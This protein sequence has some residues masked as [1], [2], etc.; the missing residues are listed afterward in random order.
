MKLSTIQ[1]FSSETLMHLYPISAY[2]WFSRTTT[3]ELNFRAVKMLVDTH[4]TSPEIDCSTNILDWGC[5]NLMWAL[6]LFPDASVTGVELSKE[7]L[8]YARINA[9]AANLKFKFTGIEYDKNISLCKDSFDYAISFGLIEFLDYNMF[10]FIFSEIYKALKPG[11]KLIV[12][13]HNWRLFSA[14][15]LPWIMRGGYAAYVDRTKA[16]ISKKTLL[17][18]SSDFSKLRFNV[19]DS[20]GYNPY[21]SKLWPLVFSEAFYSTHNTRLS[22]WYYSQFLVLQKTKW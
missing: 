13:L 19:L 14:V 22:T 17:D 21:P 2:D 11:G 20:G 3:S 4:L 6:G 7:H 9:E 15:Y 5:G 10:N 12:T 1:Q 16:N 8:H 18:V